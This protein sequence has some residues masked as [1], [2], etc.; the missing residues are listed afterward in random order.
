MKKINIILV[1]ILTISF[2]F[3]SESSYSK[4][5]FKDYKKISKAQS[6]SFNE[7]L[8][9]YNKYIGQKL[10]FA[11]KQNKVIVPEYIKNYITNL[12]NYGYVNFNGSKAYL[13]KP[14]IDLLYSLINSKQITKDNPLSILS[15]FRKGRNHGALEK[16]GI[17]VCRAVDIDIYSGFRINMNNPNDALKGI[18]RIINNMPEGRYNIGLPRPGGGQLIA[19]DKDFFLPVTNLNQNEVSPTGSI[20]TDLKLIKNQEA[21]ELITNAVKNNKMAKILYLMPDAVDHV[22]I[23]ALDDNKLY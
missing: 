12:S 17:V 13:S 11:I 4:S 19:P 1:S 16:D 3:Y 2:S 14:L 10:L 23:K 21:R 7:D 5:N 6:I 22:H 8:D 9:Y 15:L 18:V 20:D